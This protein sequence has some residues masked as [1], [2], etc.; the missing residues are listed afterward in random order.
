MLEVDGRQDDPAVAEP[1][2]LTRD[3]TG[4]VHF[5]RGGLGRGGEPCGTSVESGTQHHDLG[6]AIGNRPRDG[7]VEI[8]LAAGDAVPDPGRITVHQRSE[9]GADHTQPE[10]GAQR[11]G[12]HRGGQFVGEQALL[13]RLPLFAGR[14][15][16]RHERR[17]RLI[18]GHRHPS[19]RRR[20]ISMQS[21]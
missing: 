10:Q 15:H 6:D 17:V 14:D 9:P 13:R 11:R 20:R 1:A 16:H 4:Q 8:P 3:G 7:I 18:G 19:L 5:H 12:Q 21:I 2:P